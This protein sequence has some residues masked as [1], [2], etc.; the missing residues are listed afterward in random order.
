MDKMNILKL[1]NEIKNKIYSPYSLLVA[2][3]MLYEG[4]DGHTKEELD[5]ILKNEKITKLDNIGN[6]L[7]ILNRMYIKDTDNRLINEGYKIIIKDKYNA[8]VVLDPLDGVD[9]INNYIEESTFGQIRNMLRE[10]YGNLFLINTLAVDMEWPYQIRGDEVGEGLFENLIVSYVYGFSKYNA[11]YYKDDEVTSVGLELK[12]YDNNRYEC[13]LIQ[14]DSIELNDYINNMDDNK[15]N[16]ILSNLA[17]LEDDPRTINICIPKF[18]FSY[19]LDADKVFS[20]LG[21]DLTNP[22]LKNI[23]DINDE[24]KILHKSNIDFSEKGLKAASA[25]I[26]E[27]RCRA[28]FRDPEK[29][30]DIVIHKP[31]IPL[32]SPLSPPD[33]GRPRGLLYLFICY[34]VHHSYPITRKE[35]ERLMV[36]ISQICLARRFMLWKRS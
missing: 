5:N 36:S 16:N 7:S 29:I 9:V 32:Y 28:V 2:L 3:Y 21:L 14:P 10:I 12:Q 22:D 27:I 24:M 31:F 13:V 33:L 15:L 23:A 6:V 17:E 8:D 1:N 26:V 34:L 18:S 35:R 4:A 19:E 11:S 20:S 25:T 30:L